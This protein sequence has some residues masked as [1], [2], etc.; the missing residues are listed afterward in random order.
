MVDSA[1][2]PRPNGHADGERHREGPERRQR[3]GEDE[4]D[5][6]KLLERGL[7]ENAVK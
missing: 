6:G 2:L 7:G 5:L 3:G 1:I 4:I